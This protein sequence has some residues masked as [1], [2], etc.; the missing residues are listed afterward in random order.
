MSLKPSI[1]RFEENKV[2][3]SDGQQEPFDLV[4]FCTGYRPVIS[5]LSELELEMNAP[6]CRFH[7]IGI[8]GGRTSRSRFLRGIREDAAFIAGLISKR[9]EGR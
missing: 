1:T 6:H 2:F 8:D 7:K 3:F 5:H 4:L 9:K